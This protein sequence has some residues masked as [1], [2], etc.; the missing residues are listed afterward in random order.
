MLILFCFALSCNKTDD[1]NYP[2]V[3]LTFSPSGSYASEKK[4]VVFGA[5]YQSTWIK[6]FELL[7]PNWHYSWGSTRPENYPSEVDYVPMIWG[8]N[9]ASDEVIDELKELYESNTIKY[10]LGFNEPD[11]EDQANMTVNEAIELWPKLESI[12]APLGSPVTASPSSSWLSN[13]MNAAKNQNLRVD[14]IALHIY[15]IANPETFL[16]KIDEIHST[17]NLP[18]WITEFALRD[19]QANDNKPNKYSVE[20][21]LS[22]MK[23][24]LPGL[25]S[26]SYVKRYSWF[27]TSTDNKNY[28]KLRTADLINEN[29][30]LTAI[31]S[32]YSTYIP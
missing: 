6:K 17:Y 7:N 26:R 2:E 23:E 10:V 13:F 18:I 27:D 28:E 32:Y 21:V 31:G 22:F 4:G 19:F 25:E 29:D 5:R 30:E 8:K 3:D 24:V 20:D 12:G 9:S 15:D 1:V 16:N 11:L 14:F